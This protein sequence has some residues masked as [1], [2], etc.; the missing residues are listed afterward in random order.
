MVYNP[1]D[2]S[3]LELRF[4]R[5]F[6]Q[7]FGCRV[8]DILIPQYRLE[9]N[10]QIYRIDYAY[11]TEANRIAIELDGH[12]KIKDAAE[13]KEEFKKLLNRQNDIVQ[14]GFIVYRFTWD[15]VVKRGGWRARKRLQQVFRGK[16]KTQR[17][18]NPLQWL[19]PLGFTE[20]LQAVEP[21]PS[22]PDN[23]PIYTATA[24]VVDYIPAQQIEQNDVKKYKTLSYV[25]FG[26]LAMVMLSVLMLK[27]SEPESHEIKPQTVIQDEKSKPSEPVKVVIQVEPPQHPQG[28]NRIIRETR[29]VNY[30]K[31]QPAPTG[32]K[33]VN[34]TSEPLPKP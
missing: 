22:G 30:I 5:L 18:N 15:D 1:A 14:A 32:R 33:P 13:S 21:Q 7:I 9:V 16:I 11:V 29:V 2:R 4:E 27:G 20:N 10:G 25:G 8:E 17:K 6:Q 28:Q 3:E 31:P 24:T 19:V 23:Q 34:N 26:I 12:S